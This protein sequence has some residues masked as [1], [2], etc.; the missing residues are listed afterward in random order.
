MRTLNDNQS[1]NLV[2]HFTKTILIGFWEPQGTFYSCE[3]NWSGAILYTTF[4]GQKKSGGKMR[5]LREKM[6]ICFWGFNKV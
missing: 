4:L 1:S 5:F 3:N 6:N 2:M